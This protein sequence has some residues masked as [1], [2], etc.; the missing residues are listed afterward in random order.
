MK[1]LYISPDIDTDNPAV[2]S[3]IYHTISKLAIDGIKVNHSQLIPVENND[4]DLTDSLFIYKEG[5]TLKYRV[6]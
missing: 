3:Y 2:L 1:T 5:F 6:K 4:N